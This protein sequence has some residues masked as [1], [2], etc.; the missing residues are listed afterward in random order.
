MLLLIDAGNTNIVFA[1]RND[2][3]WLGVWRMSMLPQ[4]TADEYRVCL[5][6]FFHNN[7]I[8]PRAITH[9]AIATVVPA[10]LWNLQHLCRTYFDVEPLV[11]HVD[12]NWGFSIEVDNPKEVGADRLLNG[13]AAHHY[14]RGPLVVIDFGTAT[15]FDVVDEHGN[16]CGGVI[17][18]GITL[19]LSALHQS[20]ARLPRIGLSYP[21]RNGVVGHNTVDAMRSGIYWGYIGLM[22]GIVD[23]IRREM[24]KPL[25]IVATGGL[26]SLFAKGTKLIEHVDEMLTL[27]GLVLL[28]QRNRHP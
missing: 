15:T 18:P 17:A 9:A 3:T 19:S 23:R 13:M 25:K 28:V 12:L 4:R 22:E 2:D 11:A 26:S 27:K 6:S 5:D 1:V 10:S 20:A 8:D 14:Y 7:G 16:Y 21:G 24:N